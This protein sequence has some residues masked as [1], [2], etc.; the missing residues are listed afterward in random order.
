LNFAVHHK[1]E[2]VRFWKRLDRDSFRKSLLDSQLCGC[3]DTLS[4]MSPSALFDLYDGTL[5]RIVDEHLPV[6]EISVR[7]RQLTPW[8]D[9]DC[10]AAKRK[11]RMLER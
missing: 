6:E 7:D 8:F 11:V 4:T 5:R 9:K 2:N 10:R 3:A 1:T